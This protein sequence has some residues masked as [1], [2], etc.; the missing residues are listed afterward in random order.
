M[1]V[2]LP[3]YTGAIAESVVN[4]PVEMDAVEEIAADAA[5]APPAINKAAT[6]S[7]GLGCHAGAAELKAAAEAAGKSMAALVGEIDVT[8][9]MRPLASALRVHALAAAARRP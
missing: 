5:A 4:D 9:G 7:D 8:R 3:R 6:S 1:N 2:I